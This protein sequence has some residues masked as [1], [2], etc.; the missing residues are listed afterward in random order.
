MTT[1][2][3]VSGAC[4]TG[5]REHEQIVRRRGVRILE[6]SALVREVP[7]VGVARVDLLRAWRR[8][9]CRATSA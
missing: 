4:I 6:D 7:E 9:E 1:F 3:G 2:S 5:S 8:S